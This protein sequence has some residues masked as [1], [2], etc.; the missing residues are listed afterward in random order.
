M[1]YTIDIQVASEHPDIPSTSSFRRWVDHALRGRLPEAELSI[2]IVDEQESQALNSQYR[3][4]DKPTNVLSFP[5]EMPEG[6]PT[7]ALNH[8]LGDLIICAPVV[9][10]E[11]NEQ[12]KDLQNHW[13]HMVIHGTLHLLGY[14]HIN[15]EEADEMEQL[16]RDI[17]TVMNIPDPYQGENEV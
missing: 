2:R 8:L 14:D 12:T 7:D 13:A 15:D 1:T 17:L 3:N 6:I 5:F 11:A 10:Q 16:E 4:K 9:E